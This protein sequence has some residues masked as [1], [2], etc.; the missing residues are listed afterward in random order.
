MFCGKNSRRCIY[1]GVLI[2]VLTYI[3]TI[4]TRLHSTYKWIQNIEIIS[5]IILAT[6][7]DTIFFFASSAAVNGMVQAVFT[8]PI[9][10]V[11]FCRYRM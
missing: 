8:V 2:Y 5:L 11:P 7:Y 4:S 1:Q 3:R 9:L 10:S 6:S